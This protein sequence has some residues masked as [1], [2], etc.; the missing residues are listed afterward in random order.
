MQEKHI[1]SVIFYLN[2]HTFCVNT[3][4]YYAKCVKK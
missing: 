1:E 2:K 4:I 3:N